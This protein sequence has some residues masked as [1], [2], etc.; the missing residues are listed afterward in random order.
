MTMCED[1]T[2]DRPSHHE[3]GLKSNRQNMQNFCLAEP[4][5]VSSTIF[6]VEV[7]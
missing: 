5:S 6:Y 1:R 4:R 7:S 3:D 2:V